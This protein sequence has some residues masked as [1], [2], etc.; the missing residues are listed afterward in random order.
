[1]PGM[2]GGA[3]IWTDFFVAYA[4]TLVAGMVGGQLKWM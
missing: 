4:V 3:P 2:E 1:M